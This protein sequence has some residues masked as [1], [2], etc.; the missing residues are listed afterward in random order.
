MRIDRLQ[1]ENFKGFD[2]REFNFHPQ[3]NLICGVNGTGKTT[4]LDAL[5][6]AAGSWFLGL[7]EESSAR[8]IRQHEV[9]I[10]ELPQSEERNQVDGSLRIDLVEQF[11]CSVSAEGLVQGKV[12]QWQRSLESKRSRTTTKQATQLMELSQDA[13]VSVR[14]GRTLTLP[15]ISYYGTGRLWEVPREQAHIKSQKQLGKRENH[16]RFA[17]YKNSIEP[18]LSVAD[19][20]RWIA[21]QNWSAFQAGGDPN[22]IYQVVKKAIL[23]CIE[24]ATDLF[25][26]P[27]RGEVIV[28]VEKQGRQPFNNLSDGQRCMLSLI[29]DLAHKAATL[30]PGL[31]EAALL[32]TNGVVLIDELDL[33]LHPIWQRRV[34]EDLR[35]TFPNLQ[36][37]ATTHSP[38]LIQ[39]LRSG[40]ELLMLDGAATAQLANKTLE[41]IAQDIMGVPHSEVSQ[42]YFEMKQTARQYLERLQS[43]DTSPDQK[44]KEFKAELAKAISPFADNPAYQAFLEMKQAAKIGE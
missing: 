10:K 36:F 21:E 39:S 38:F 15:L 42:R 44:L 14:D 6:I 22:G 18:R 19:L 40:E 30:N 24:G 1:V 37:F 20:T 35:R 43:L 2:K 3:M 23:S 33:H 32:E 12:I 27:N 17:G 4:I 7:R 16:S 28:E 26:A 11:P 5:A 13:D 34:I 41:D 8:H 9:R 25:Y 29:G 31:G